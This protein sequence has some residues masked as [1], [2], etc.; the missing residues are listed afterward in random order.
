M[1]DWYVYIIVCS[2]GTLYTGITTDPE[3]RLKEHNKG[4]AA[5][6]TS[7]RTPVK[8]K[9]LETARNRSEAS[10][11]ERAV[12]KMSRLEKIALC[13]KGKTLSPKP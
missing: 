6:Y 7:S 12:K 13:G 11:R 5:K 8:L 1:N 3:R 4:K 10:K 2:D 9:Y